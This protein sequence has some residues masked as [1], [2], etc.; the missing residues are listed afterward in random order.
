MSTLASQAGLAPNALDEVFESAEDCILAAFS[1][2]LD[3]LS[4]RVVDAACDKEAWLE[5]I[6]AGLLALLEFLDAEPHWAHLLIL[7]QPLEGTAAFR[8]AERLHEALADVF[9]LARQELIVGAELAPPAGL[10]AELLSCAVYSVIRRCILAGTGEA[11]ASLA[12]SLMT[13]IIEPYLARGAEK[14]DSATSPASAQ[15]GPVEAKVI[16]IRPHPRVMAALHAIN[17]VPR[18]SSREVAIAVGLGDKDRR[19]TSDLLG[20]LQQRGLIE[21]AN[22]RR[23]GRE[24][25]LWLMTP[26]G[27]RVLELITASLGSARLREQRHG[28]PGRTSRREPEPSGRRRV[29]TA[30][31]A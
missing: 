27:R 20:R 13:H 28:V 9:E 10:L 12:P 3:R 31:T 30:A 16:P 11:L 29:T 24:R 6:E 15:E 17:S 23:A 5:R 1:E 4:A 21:N 8:C 2:G 25:C 26:Y 19:R 14:A 18:S 22:Q 7:E